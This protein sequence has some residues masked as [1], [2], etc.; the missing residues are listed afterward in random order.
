MADGFGAAYIGSMEFFSR[1]SPL[2]A[3]RD[4]R[5]FLA[6]RGPIEILFLV[7]AMGITLTLV[8]AFARDSA[9][10][11]TYRPNIIYVEQYRLDRSDAEIRA[12]QKVDAVAKEKRMAERRRRDLERQAGF[13]RLDDKLRSYGF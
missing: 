7:A 4:L 9:I 11:P 1:L 5:A 13:K 10:P 3:Y 12:Q 6:H 8:W 2:R